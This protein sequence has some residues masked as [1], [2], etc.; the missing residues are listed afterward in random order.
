MS[1]PRTKPPG[2]LMVW[3]DRIHRWTGGIIGLLLAAMGI[4]G[5]LLIH[6][7]AWLRATVPH[8]AD[9]LVL[10]ATAVTAAAERLVADASQPTSIIFPKDGLGL[11]TLSF[12]GGGGA[13]ADQSGTIVARWTS[14]WDR[15]ELWLF[16]FHHH[17]WMGDTGTTVAGF[18]ALIGLGFVIT[19]VLLWWRTRK[20]F[21]LRLVPA[22]LSRLQIIRHH[23]DLGVVMAPL[24]FVL[25]LT[26]AMVTLR[27]VAEVLLAPLSAPGTIEKSL[28]PPKVKGGPLAADFDWGAALQTVR[29]T[30]PEAELRTI[31]IPRRGNGLIRVRVR[32]PPE[33]LP[34]GRTIFWFD[35]ADGRL[36][37][38]R[39]AT[40]LP[41]ATRAYNLVYPI[42]ASKIGGFAYKAA[43]TAAGLSLIFLGTLAVYGFWGYRARRAVRPAPA[44]RAVQEAPGS[45]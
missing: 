17:L 31:G 42:H 12:D 6:K 7:D 39:D 40:T 13:Y 32:Q 30:W 29:N 3:L 21:K 44:T 5:T 11:F 4:S 28:A 43:M 2:P 22:S 9:A 8:A 36:V 26:A 45:P 24:L 1:T 35:A 33:W 20:D 25:F 18:L 27:P 41:L 38:S 19:G 14:T 16:D 37:E 34:N 23:R 10:D 15:L